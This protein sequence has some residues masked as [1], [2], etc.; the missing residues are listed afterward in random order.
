MIYLGGWDGADKVTRT[1][2][3][4]QGLVSGKSTGDVGL[5]IAA[6]QE[7][8]EVH[9]LRGE[10]F[11]RPPSAKEQATM[12]S[13]ALTRAATGW[14][15]EL[16]AAGVNVNLAPVTD[17]V[18]ADIGR[19]NEPIGRCGRQYGSDPETVERGL[20]RVPQGDA[21][22]RRRGHGQALPR[23]GSDP[24]QHRLQRPPASPTT[25][26]TPTTPSWSRSRRG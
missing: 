1:S 9:Q 17:T 3:H 21:G 16:K 8:G 2:E 10:G 24:Q 7:G 15:R 6:D 11:T 22:R 5:L 19:A 4:L 23:A 18:P 14:A 20:D 13:A 25:S 12:S 26:P